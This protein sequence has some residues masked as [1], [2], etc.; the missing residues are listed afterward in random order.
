SHAGNEFDIF[1][2]LESSAHFPFRGA[3]IFLT[4]I[5][6]GKDLAY[7]Q[8]SN[9]GSPLG[10]QQA[11]QNLIKPYKK[12]TWTLKQQVEYGKTATYAGMEYVAQNHEKLLYY[13]LFAS[14]NSYTKNGVESGSYAFVI[15]ADQRDDYAT[16]ELL[17]QLEMTEV[18]IHQAT[19]SFKAGG[20]AYQKGSYVIQLQQ[21]R[22]NWAHQALGI[23]EYPEDGTD[24]DLEATSNMPMWLGV[25]A[26]E[27]D[28]KFDADLTRVDEVDVPVVEMPEAPG[29]DGAY[30]VSP[31]SYGTIEIVTALQDKNI[32]T[33][34]SAK[35]FRR[36][37]QEFPART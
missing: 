32:R 23:D 26:D 17:K 36:A 31:E 1:W 30:L 14:A 29:E 13:N 25:E 20:N 18:E 5:A 22:A 11:R 15:P 4:E 19:S 28:T 27:I 10:P 35:S 37:G 21:P 16:Y 7:P 2:S 12:D 3:G 6:T 34:R 24:T 33:I 8:K 9:D